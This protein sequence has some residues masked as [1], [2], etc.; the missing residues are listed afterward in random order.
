MLAGIF[1]KKSDHPLADIKSVQ[2][3]L[4]NLPKNDAYKSLME[5]TDLIESATEHDEF[6]LDHQFAVVRMIDE[7]A[8]PYARK[9]SA[10][11]FYPVR[12]KQIP[13]KIVYG[14]YWAIITAKPPMPITR[15]SIVFATPRRAVAPSGYTYRC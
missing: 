4:E 1:G 15:C 14:R 8:Q 2:A 11:V 12:D 6:K 10:R 7:A 5:L 3:L 13:G 9:L